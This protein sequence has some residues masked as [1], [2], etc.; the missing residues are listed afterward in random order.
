M[1]KGL[2]QLQWAAALNADIQRG[3]RCKTDLKL[4][5]RRLGKAK[6][7]M[8][9][10]HWVS[11]EK[12]TAHSA[13]E[14]ACLHFVLEPLEGDLCKYSLQLGGRADTMQKVKDAK[15]K[16]TCLGLSDGPAT[17]DPTQAEQRMPL[18]KGFTDH[19]LFV[20]PLNFQTLASF[21]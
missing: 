9:R 11:G 2:G 14:T 13:E 10:V 17:E 21:C 4:L 5:C 12:G 16:I 18:L 6:C 19:G 8:G 7:V 3:I 20:P 1:C 15:C